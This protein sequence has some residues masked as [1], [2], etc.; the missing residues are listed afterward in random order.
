M[1]EMNWQRGLEQKCGHC[2]HSLNEGFAKCHECG[3]VREEFREYSSLIRDEV[4]G[5]IFSGAET[6]VFLPC[7]HA[8]WAPYFL[9]MIEAGWLDTSFGYT[10]LAYHTNP[11]LRSFG[12]S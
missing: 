1:A 9:S 4:E 5:C 8:V 11:Q 10:E 7:G 2:H 3:A 12:R 6:D